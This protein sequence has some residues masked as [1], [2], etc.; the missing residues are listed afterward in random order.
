MKRQKLIDF[1]GNK[2][3]SAMAKEYGVS[4]Q[5]WSYWEI[6]TFTPPPHIMK[7]LENDVG[8]PMEEI[9]FDVFNQETR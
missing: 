2:T 8:I 6:G 3:Q 9:F 5:T 4:Q 1:R 7:R